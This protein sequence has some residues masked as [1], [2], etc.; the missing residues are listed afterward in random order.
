MLKNSAKVMSNPSQIILI[1]SSFGFKL[2][3]YKI[4]LIEDG[5]NAQMVA[6]L[7]IEMLRWSQSSKILFL[8]ALTVSIIITY[9][10]MS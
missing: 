8:T 4:L 5:G 6:N 3:P 1:V 7:F 9:L 2:R 10:I